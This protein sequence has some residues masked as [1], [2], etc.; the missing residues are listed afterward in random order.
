MT[1]QNFLNQL[2][3]KRIGWTEEG[4]LEFSQL[5]PFLEA[6]ALAF[7][8]ENLSIT[9]G[10]STPMSEESLIE[11]LLVRGEGGLCYELNTLLYLFLANNGFDVTMTRGIVYNHELQHWPAAGR[12]H[13][14]VILTEQGERYLLDT[15]FGINHA[16]RPLPLAG[17]TA[18]SRNGSFRLRRETTPYGDYVYE[19][20]L[21]GRVESWRIGYAFDS[22]LALTSLDEPREVQE[23]IERHPE[24]PFN[25][26][27]LAAKLTENGSMSLSPQSFT[28]WID[29]KMTK[30][31]ISEAEYAD[32]LRLFGL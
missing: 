25:K 23:I 26:K 21:S 12:T 8:F 13:I 9:S 27:P 15:G 7:P 11:K 10:S 22:T 32:K 4:K 20:M 19:M 24:S 31:P 30:T 28:Q 14:A 17:K 5:G 6:A 1:N 18:E 2:F 3:R 29:G 16:L